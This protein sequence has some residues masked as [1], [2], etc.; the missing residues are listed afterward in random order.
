M[1]E[2]YMEIGMMVSSSE[3]FERIDMIEESIEL[4]AI[5]GRSDKAKERALEMIEKKPTPKI[6]C[7]YGD[8]TGDITY[9]QKAWYCIILPSSIFYLSFNHYYS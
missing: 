7:V 3:L 1:A 9:Y 5:A 6:Y 2:K 8:L 4:L